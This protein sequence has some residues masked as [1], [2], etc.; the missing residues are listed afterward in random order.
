[1]RIAI[2]QTS[3]VGLR[4][5]RIILAEPDLI[6]LGLV[7]RDPKNDHDDRIRRADGLAGYD[8]VVVDDL[9]AA[10]EITERALMDGT[11]VCLW[12][13]YDSDPWD[14]G[15]IDRTSSILTGTN[16]ASGIAPCLAAHE[17][18]RGG[19]L[20]DVTLA[21][22]EP[23]TPLRRGEAVPFPGP[24]GARWAKPRR[25]GDETVLV[26]PV[27]GEWAGAIARVTSATD[28]GVVTRIVGVA[29]LDAHLEALALAAGAI[30][31]GRGAFPLGATTP[32]DA[33]EAYLAAALNAGLG[34]AAYELQDD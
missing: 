15:F 14:G 29:D 27:D 18:A 5:A 2:H 13:E 6:E 28:S 11:A 17:R 16:L 25:V 20:M 34:V 30:A 19:H 10:D 9:D 8:A 7:G 3:E 33:A 24:V 4:A 32:I 1:V 26:A 12:H 23:G 21:W 31:L 22:T